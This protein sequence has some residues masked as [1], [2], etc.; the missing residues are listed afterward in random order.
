MRVTRNDEV[1][2]LCRAIYRPADQQRY[3]A[4][5][6]PKMTVTSGN[7]PQTAAATTVARFMRRH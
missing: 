5:R 6:P 1:R 7:Y 4:F 2:Q 3:R